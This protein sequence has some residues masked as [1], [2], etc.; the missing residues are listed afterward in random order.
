[1][2]SLDRQKHG[3]VIAEFLNEMAATQKDAFILKGGTA[4]LTCYG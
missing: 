1:M 2:D 4:L 3:K